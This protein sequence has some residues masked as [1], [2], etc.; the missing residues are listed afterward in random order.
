V[1]RR[2]SGVLL[3]AAAGAALWWFVVRA[4]T[5]QEA[6]P[7][8]GEGDGATLEVY[9][10]SGRDGLARRVTRDLRH[11]AFDVVYFGT[12]PFDTLTTTLLKVHRGDTLQ[13]AAIRDVLGTGIILVEP[14]PR[15]LLDV[16]VFLG[17]DVRTPREFSP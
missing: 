12:A 11:H 14:D 10:A 3:L 4:P 16:S 15:A 6:Y 8:P 13:A 1:R 5:P 17:R 2:L 7:I 9:N